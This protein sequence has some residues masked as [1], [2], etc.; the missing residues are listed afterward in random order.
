MKKLER[1]DICSCEEAMSYRAVLKEI[2][3][4]ASNER[5]DPR[6]IVDLVDAALK[7][8]Y[9]DSGFP[10]V[11]NFADRVTRRNWTEKEIERTS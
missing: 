7:K 8:D 2:R 5:S 9:A 10:T 3:R 11:L 1:V 6:A 4:L